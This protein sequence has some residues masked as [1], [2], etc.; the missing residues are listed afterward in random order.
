MKFFHKILFVLLISNLAI[1]LVFNSDFL[2]ETVH[3]EKPNEP[4]EKLVNLKLT[5]TRLDNLFALMQLKESLYLRVNDRLGLFSIEKVLKNKSLRFLNDIQEFLGVENGKVVS[6]DK[7]VRYLNNK[8]LFYSFEKLGSNN[9][10]G[11][12]EIV[13]H[14][15]S[16][17]V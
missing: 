1:F 10:N 16:L 17:K 5:H 12:L 6:T 2:K 15:S 9:S 13:T 4:F 14:F 11:K 8:S 7:F 3:N